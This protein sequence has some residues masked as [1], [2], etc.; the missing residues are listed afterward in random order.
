MLIRCLALAA[1]LCASLSLAA[2]TPPKQTQTRKGPT[3]RA[4]AAAPALA[5][6]TAEQKEA[7]ALVLLG[8]SACEFDH[9]LTVA[10][11]AGQEAYFDVGYRKTRFTMKPVLSSTGA[12]RLEDVRGQTLLLQIAYKSMLMDVRAGRRLADNCVH[13]DQAARQRAAESAAAAAAEAAA[14]APAPAASAASQPG[15]TPH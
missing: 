15:G 11:L 6:A 12:V 3:T 9:V 1:G 4:A 2:Q 14:S 7:A 13:Q 10:P 8:E 5:A